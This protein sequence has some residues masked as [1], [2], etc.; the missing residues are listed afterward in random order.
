MACS[1]SRGGRFNHSLTLPL[2]ISPLSLNPFCPPPLLL[3]DLQAMGRLTGVIDDRGKFIHISME[4]MQEVAKFI[5]LHG[6]I[7]IADLAAASSSLVNLT[8][9]T[10][11][12]TLES[13]T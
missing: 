6:R 11:L 3:Q 7:S 13:E 1:E 9:Q 8:P 12:L 4:E 5:R 2:V 10:E